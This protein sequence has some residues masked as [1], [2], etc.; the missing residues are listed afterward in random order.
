MLLPRTIDKARGLIQGGDPGEY[1]ITPG[2]SAWLLGQ[3]GMNEAEFLELVRASTTEDE[4]ADA[5][6]ARVSQDRRT[7]LNELVKG[8]RVCDL[9]AP[10]RDE[11]LR[12]HGPQDAEKIVIEVLVAD[13]RATF[14]AFR[15]GRDPVWHAADRP[16]GSPP[17][18]V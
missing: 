8:L 6:A 15:L 3:V 17:G 1:R 2:L 16:E 7:V 18:R 9:S 5:V 4:V 13:D 12:L 10:L 14:G 11:F